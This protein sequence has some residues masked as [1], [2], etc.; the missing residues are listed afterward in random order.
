MTKKKDN[1]KRER[2]T[3]LGPAIKFRLA[4]NDLLHR[5]CLLKKCVR[6]R[7]LCACSF[8]CF[9]SVCLSLCACTSIRDISASNTVQYEY[10]F[11]RF[12]EWISSLTVSRISFQFKNCVL[13][14]IISY[15]FLHF[16]P[17]HYVRLTIVLV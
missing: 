17:L 15:F 7:V 5:Q 2:D 9:M 14:F 11:S 3:T 10:K 12:T 16:I 1:E 4:I 13:F 8:V 6:V